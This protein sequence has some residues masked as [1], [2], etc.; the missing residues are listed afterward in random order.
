MAEIERTISKEINRKRLAE[1]I[2][3]VFSDYE[4]LHACQKEVDT[5][6]KFFFT[7]PTIDEAA[8]DLIISTHDATT[9]SK[10]AIIEIYKQRE[11]DGY[12]YFSSVRADLVLMVMAETID[13]TDAVFIEG[14]LKDAKAMVL[15][16]DWLTAAHEMTLVVVEGAYTQDIHDGIKNYIDDYVTNNY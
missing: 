11:V 16:G 14:K 2:L 13:S 12:N 9:T 3:A 4:G 15:S 10:E 1:E 8:L 7:S 5:D 6:Y